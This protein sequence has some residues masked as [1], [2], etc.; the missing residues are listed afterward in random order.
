[1]I[2]AFV[3]AEVKLALR[4]MSAIPNAPFPPKKPIFKDFCLRRRSKDRHCSSRLI[5]Q[6]A[7]SKF[8][9]KMCAAVNSEISLSLSVAMIMRK[10]RFENFPGFYRVYWA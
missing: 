3:S 8:L 9:V 6:Y 10:C 7:V 1:M 2:I 5:S 4:G